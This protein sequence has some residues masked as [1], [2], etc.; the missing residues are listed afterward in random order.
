MTRNDRYSAAQVAVATVFVPGR[1]FH[2][3]LMFVGKA[4]EYPS[5]RCST[6]EESPGFTRKHQTRLERLARDKDSS[7]FVN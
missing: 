4:G 6:Q 1:S 2:S 5:V 7:L 3:N